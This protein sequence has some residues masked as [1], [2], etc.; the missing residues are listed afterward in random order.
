MQS[1]ITN[2]TE[3]RASPLRRG[4]DIPMKAMF[5]P[6]RFIDEA[7]EHLESIAP[8]KPIWFTE[9]NVGSRGLKQWKN[10]G[11][12]LLF[13]GA[14]VSRILHHREA[15]E[16]SCFHQIYESNFGTFFYDKSSGIETLPSYE[17]FRLVGAAWHEAE[18]LVPTTFSDSDSLVGFSTRGEDGIRLFVTN[19]SSQSV[20]LKLDKKGFDW[21][22]ITLDATPEA[23]L[24]PSSVLTKELELGEND[25]VLPAHS[26]NLLGPE[27]VISGAKRTERKASG[28]LLP[29]R[30]HLTLWYPPFA[31]KQPRVDATGSYALDCST[32]SD[33]KSALVKWSLSGIGP[34]TGKSYRVSFEAKSTPA[35]GFTLKLP[36]PSQAEGKWVQ[37]NPKFET[38]T[39][40]FS[41]D[42]KQNEG[43]VSLFFSEGAIQKA[44]KL[45]MRNF[46]I[47][48][49]D[50]ESQ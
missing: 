39:F 12:E 28:N 15:F 18:Q 40:E 20:S 45:E 44:G 6:E 46:R 27:T 19:R 14:S 36:D 42:A 38:V 5:R 16:W 4:T 34:E 3:D 7:V 41:F 43:E 11:A 23:M 49:I 35:I 29:P 10:S 13:L 17:F 48:S 9:W 2:T 31:R 33:K 26:I 50:P 8:E 25:A 32:F 47:S 30:P 37:T 22:G 1:S 24:A 21:R